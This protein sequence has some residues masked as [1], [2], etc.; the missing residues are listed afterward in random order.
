V[1]EFLHFVLE[2]LKIIK[3]IQKIIFFSKIKK[4]IDFTS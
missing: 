3:K 4:N 1:L 2:Y